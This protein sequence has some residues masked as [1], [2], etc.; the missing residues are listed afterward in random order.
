M[1]TSDKDS[2]REE[3]CC[4]WQEKLALRADKH[5]TTIKENVFMNF[6]KLMSIIIRIYRGYL[7]IYISFSCFYCS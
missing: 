2:L 5:S 1:T 4:H 6:L 3:K 7:V